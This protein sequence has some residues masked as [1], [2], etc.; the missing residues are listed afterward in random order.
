MAQQTAD[1]SSKRESP[2]PVVDTLAILGKTCVRT[3]A[4]KY[5]T[6]KGVSMQLFFPL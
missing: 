4:S 5:L 6:P 3:C 1:G 2:F